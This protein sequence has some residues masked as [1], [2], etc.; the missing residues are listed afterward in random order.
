MKRTPLFECHRESNARF[1]DFGGWEMP[2]Q[3]TGIQSEHAAVRS[4][5]GLFDVSHMG[6]VEV[7]GPNAVDAVNALITNDL[8]QIADGQACYTAM[9]YPYGGIVDDLVVYRFSSTRVLICVNAANRQKDFEWI[10]DHLKGAEAVDLSD[11]YAQIAVQGPRAQALLSTF[12]S[13]DLSE[14][15]RYWFLEG[16]LAGV[17]C[18]ISRTG[19]TGE[20]GFELYCPAD[21]GADLW[22]ALM[23]HQ[24]P[25]TPA[26]LGAR[27][28]LRLE[29]KYALYGNDINDDTTPLEAGLSWL[30][31]LKKDHFIGR[32]ALI[33]QKEAGIPRFLVAFQ[34]SGRAIARHGYAVIDEQGE[35]IGEVT[36]GTRSPTFGV[37]IGMAYV[38]YAMRKV[39]TPLKIQVRKKV[40][41][42]TIVRLP[43]KKQ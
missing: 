23:E 32:E 30:T 2:V 33:A 35:V 3:Y 22:R 25:P 41:E 27:D 21:R 36:S 28:T 12:T 11:E 24:R 9:C 6:E 7:T 1:V 29:H 20:D 43:L 13:T 4:D 38:P 39:G 5:V 18:I 17:P 19:Y 42:A 26:G 37:G 31:K 14:I 10:S 16:E 40:E 8:S 34:M 15:E